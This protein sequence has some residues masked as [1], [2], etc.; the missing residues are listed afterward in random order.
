MGS[1]NIQIKTAAQKERSRDKKSK[2]QKGHQSSRSRPDRHDGNINILEVDE[3]DGDEAQKLRRHLQ[4]VDQNTELGETLL[5]A[6][7]QRIFSGRPS[8]D[9]FP[10]E[11]TMYGIWDEI[12]TRKKS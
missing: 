12:T 11:D 6:P 1:T 7:G 8:V 10:G 5:S 2:K 3:H 4:N 9:A